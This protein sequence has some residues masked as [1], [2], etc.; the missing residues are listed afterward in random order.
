MDAKSTLMLNQHCGGRMSLLELLIPL[1]QRSPCFI[2][3][4]CLRKEEMESQCL[5]KA[6][7]FAPLFR[8]SWWTSLT[9]KVLLTVWRCASHIL[10]SF[11]EIR[12]L[13]VISNSSSVGGR[14]LCLSNTSRIIVSSLQAESMIMHH[15]AS[16]NVHSI[17]HLH[18]QDSWYHW[19][20]IIWYTW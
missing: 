5:V 18:S 13:L 8:L 1:S 10:T 4:L 12:T 20:K 17:L 3:Y 16:L 14:S 2:Y 6:A 15:L 19:S 11:G 7:I 9:Q